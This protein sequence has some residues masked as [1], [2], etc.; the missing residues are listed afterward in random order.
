MVRTSVSLK[1]ARVVVQ[2]MADAM[3]LDLVSKRLVTDQLVL[4]VGYDAKS[5]ANPEIRAK[6]Q[7]EITTNHFGKTV[8][9]HAHG[10]F[11]FEKPFASFEVRQ[12]LNES[13]ATTALT[14]GRACSRSETET[15]FT[16]S[17]L[18]ASFI[19]LQPQYRN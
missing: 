4:T 8:S 12:P 6:Y 16:F 2:E 15:S 1:K 14:F 5:L 19:R 9:K 18:I 13:I 3:A 7:G 11:N 17:R 10:S